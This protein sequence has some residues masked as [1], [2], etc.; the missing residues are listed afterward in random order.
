MNRHLL[1]ALI[2]FLIFGSCNNK[3]LNIL[4]ITSDRKLPSEGFYEMFESFDRKNYTEVKQPKANARIEA[5]KAN[6]FDV[7]VFYDLTDSITLSQKEA[8]MQLLE[9]GKPMIF[10]HH[11]LVS[12]QDW[13]EYT[14]IIGG[15]YIRDD[16]IRGP[17]TFRHDVDI[18]VT[19]IDSFHPVTKGL[20][21]FIILDET[22][23]KC[24]ILDNVIP[25]LT[26][27]IESSM[28]ILSWINKYKSSEIVYIQTGHDDPAFDNPN[29]RQLVNQAINIYFFNTLTLF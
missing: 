2:L 1:F 15:K 19:V 17:S 4:L 29:Y 13:P 3:E 9:D 21:D 27:N 23:D 16:S 5:G 24:I 8:Y 26:T 22:Y 28:P 18:P 11:T 25:L 20:S 14:K 6:D 7:L 10:L 12:Y